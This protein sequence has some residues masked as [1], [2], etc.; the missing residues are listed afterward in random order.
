MFKLYFILLLQV[1]VQCTSN[2][3]MES[4]Q[5]HSWGAIQGSP[6]KNPFPFFHQNIKKI[7]SKILKFAVFEVCC[8]PKFY[9]L[10]IIPQFESSLCSKTFCIKVFL[11]AFVGWAFY[12]ILPGEWPIYMYAAILQPDGCAPVVPNGPWHLTFAPQW[13]QN[14]CSLHR[15]H[16]LSILDYTGSRHWAPFNFSWGTAN[17]EACSYPHAPNLVH[18]ST[19]GVLCTVSPPLF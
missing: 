13:L 4:Y 14:L 7:N 5:G 12:S 1:S 17:L 8:L 3:I 18:V 11:S 10:P 2:N 9:I 16:M 19:L 6:M 15:S